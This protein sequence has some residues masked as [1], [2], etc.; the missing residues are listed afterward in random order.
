MYEAETRRFGRPEAIGAAT[1]I[2]AALLAEPVG[3]SGS[4]VTIE[5][6]EDLADGA[7]TGLA[8]VVHTRSRWSAVTVPLA[9]PAAGRSAGS[10]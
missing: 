1:G 4:V 6:D 2:N 7:R 3:P 9:T 8:A 10:S 5:L